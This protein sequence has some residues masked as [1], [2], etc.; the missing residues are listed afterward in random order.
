[1]LSRGTS[2]S[3]A[4]DVLALRE[5]WAENFVVSIPAMLR[6]SLIH[7]EIVSLEACLCGFTKEMYSSFTTLRSYVL[8]RCSLRWS[9]IQSLLFS[10]EASSRGFTCLPTFVCFTTELYTITHLLSCSLISSTCKLWIDCPL[11][12][13]NKASSTTILSVICFSERRCVSSH[14]AKLSITVSTSQF[15]CT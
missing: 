12:P 14:S 13:E 9:T 4:A 5:L 8:C 7:L 10:K 3:K 6:T 2:L 11:C 1:M 15:Q